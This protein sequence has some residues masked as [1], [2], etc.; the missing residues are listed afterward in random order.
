MRYNIFDAEKLLLNVKDVEFILYSPIRNKRP[1]KIFIKIWHTWM[2]TSDESIT[3]KKLMIFKK[4][5]ITVF[6][7]F[8]FYSFS[9]HFKIIYP[10]YNSVYILFYNWPCKNYLQNK[11]LY[12]TKFT[13]K[14][15]K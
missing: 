12:N 4:F 11:E 10:G 7:S 13:V 1:I 3:W 5:A 8:S 15:K 14:N 6:F 9:F 2:I